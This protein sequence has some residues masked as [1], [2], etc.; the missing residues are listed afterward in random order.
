MRI[1]SED[2]NSGTNGSFTLSLGNSAFVQNVKGIAVKSVSFK[3]IFP[4]IFIGSDGIGNSIFPY[5][6]DSVAYTAAVEPGWWDAVSLAAE[7]TRLI[8]LQIP[9]T[10]TVS[11]VVSPV[12]SPAAQNSYFNFASDAEL[13]IFSRDSLITPNPM[14]EQVGISEDVI[15]PAGNNYTAAWLPQLSGLTTVYLCSN[16]FAAS[17][18]SASSNDGEIVPI[19]TEIPIDVPYL[20]EILY[21]PNDADLN[22][23]MFQNAK[24]LNSVD[25][26]ICTRSGTV[27]DLQQNDLTCTF[28]I[29]P[30]GAYATD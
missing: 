28:R 10:V 19:V 13:V 2:K 18:S 14:A 16:A 7:L 3:H 21:R 29:I 23:I 27:L 15:I 6:Y 25:L 17:N 20:G 22:T 9:G 26:A 12:N 1:S 5:V 11:L 24:S 30:Q 4:N 8:N